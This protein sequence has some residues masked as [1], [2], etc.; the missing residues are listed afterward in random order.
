MTVR[1]VP[2]CIPPAVMNPVPRASLLVWHNTIHWQNSE[3][4]WTLNTD[5]TRLGGPWCPDGRRG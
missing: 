5:N 2:S 4:A 3:L 1:Y